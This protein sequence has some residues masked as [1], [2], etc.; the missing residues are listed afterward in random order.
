MSNAHRS[1]GSLGNRA[2][3]RDQEIKTTMS[4]V[5]SNIS[6]GFVQA[7]GAQRC[8]ARSP[9]WGVQEHPT[10]CQGMGGIAWFGAGVCVK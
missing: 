3:R 1:F 10:A 5:I 2:H 8:R 4:R 6:L 9:A 7:P